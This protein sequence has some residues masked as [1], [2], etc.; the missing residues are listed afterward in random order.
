MKNYVKNSRIT[1]ISSLIMSLIGLAI[2]T[3]PT[4]AMAS[5]YSGYNGGY[6]YG[7]GGYGNY[8]GYS[9]G[10]YPH[11]V[12]PI[13]RP[14]T[15]PTYYPVNVP[16]PV[17]TPVV[18]PVIEPVYTPVYTQEPVYYSSPT[19]Y[20]QPY[21]EPISYNYPAPYEP[22]YAYSEPL[23][24][25]CSANVSFAPVGS[26]VLWTASVSGGTGYY[27]YAW[28]GS[29]QIY[30]SL[31][32]ADVAYNTPGQKYA[33]VSVYSDGQTV[34]VNCS[35][36]V[37]VGAK[38]YTNGNAPVTLAAPKPVVKYITHTVIVRAA[39]PAVTSAPTTVSAS[40][41]FS[42]AN[43]PWGWVAVL[44][45]LVLFGTVLYLLFNKHKI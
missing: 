29:D 3:V 45:I 32:S 19:Y 31:S 34:T 17:I 41:P 2:L 28:T 26:M 25:S 11:P 27:T 6:G 18:E 33:A 24:V 39:A 5:G 44:V 7:N 8:G 20:S 37:T 10:S 21:S 13:S 15:Y 12:G 9:G 16:T 35:N 4:L 22:S 42:L 38:D 36:I 1:I 14:V 30:G 43:I 23:T 40:S